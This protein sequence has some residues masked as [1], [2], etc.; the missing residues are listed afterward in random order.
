M[1]FVE[2]LKL[3]LIFEVPVKKIPIDY[4]IYSK[5]FEIFIVSIDHNEQHKGRWK[6]PVSLKVANFTTPCSKC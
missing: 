4:K 5:I 1:N 2:I 6:S 3:L